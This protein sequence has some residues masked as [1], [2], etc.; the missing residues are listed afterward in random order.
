M[1]LNV[2][3][4]DYNS[5]AAPT[6]VIMLLTVVGII[7]ALL[8]YNFVHRDGNYTTHF[9]GDWVKGVYKSAAPANHV[10]SFHSL[11]A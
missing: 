11:S 3:Q 1:S 8:G 9:N 7:A 4:R 5:H 10:L 6:A 2:L